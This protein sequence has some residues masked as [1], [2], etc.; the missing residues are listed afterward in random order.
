MGERS[1]HR[2]TGFTIQGFTRQKSRCWLGLWPHLDLRIFWTHAGSWQNSFAWGHRTETPILL[3]F[4]VWECSQLLEC[5]QDQATGAFTTQ[6]AH[7]TASCLLE[8]WQESVC[9]SCLSLSRT[10]LITS[11]PPKIISLLMNSKINNP[12][13]IYKTPLIFNVT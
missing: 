5:P 4:V 10:H 6:A 7:N 9:R 11:G 3:L 8:G 13:Y 12:S 2:V 1:E